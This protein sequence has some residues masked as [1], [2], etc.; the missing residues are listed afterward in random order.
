MN[1]QDI[2]KWSQSIVEVKSG[3]KGQERSK[4]IDVEQ[5]DDV[6][7]AVEFFTLRD[8]AGNLVRDGEQV[9]VQLVNSQHKQNERRGARASLDSFSL[10]N[11]LCEIAKEKPELRSRLNEFFSDVDVPQ[12]ED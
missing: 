9:V 3:P 12:L 7:A 1:K 10:M 5:F 4:F 11:R 2:S 6:Y 8:A